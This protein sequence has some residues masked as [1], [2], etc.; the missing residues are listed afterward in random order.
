M[1]NGDEMDRDLADALHVLNYPV[2]AV[3]VDG[4][5]RRAR[6][7]SA[8]RRWRFAA[9]AVVMLAASAAAALPGSPV[10]R[11]IVAVLSDAAA[12]SPT[13]AAPQ[14]PPVDVAPN[15]DTRGVGTIIGRSAEVVFSTPQE[16]GALVIRFIP[17]PELRIRSTD[18]VV[19]YQVR[20]TGF[21]VNNSGSRASYE[22]DVSER[23]SELRVSVGDRTVF[24]R[25]GGRVI[26]GPVARRDGAHVVSLRA[27][28]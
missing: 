1:H 17:E 13:P 28:R 27:A 20:P 7:R 5:I 24:E 9:A 6:T 22:L 2:R 23:V 8:Q 15:P 11:W 10:R 14:R 18:A 21:L 3:S 19:G 16:S 25:R 4:I 26:V 12:N